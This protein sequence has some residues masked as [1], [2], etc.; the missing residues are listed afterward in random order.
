[1]SCE[2]VFRLEAVNNSKKRMFCFLFEYVLRFKLTKYEEEI[3]SQLRSMLH[4]FHAN[5]CLVVK[6]DRLRIV[7]VFYNSFC[8]S[9]SGAKND[10]IFCVSVKTLFFFLAKVL[11]CT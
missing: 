11:F 4:V 8:G 3:F 6:V 9:P 7:S 10:F 2:L 5:C 1:M